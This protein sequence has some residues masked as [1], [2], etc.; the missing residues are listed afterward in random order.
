M[1]LQHATLQR[2]TREPQRAPC[3]VSRAACA[4]HRAPRGIALPT[5]A[6]CAVPRA[7]RPSPRANMRRAPCVARACVLRAARHRALWAP[8]THRL[9]SVLLGTPGTLDAAVYSQYRQ[10]YMV[11][12]VPR[13]PGTLDASPCALRRKQTNSTFPP[14]SIA[15]PSLCGR[16]DAQWHSGY[17]RDPLYR[18][19]LTVSQYSVVLTVRMQRPTL[20]R[21]GIPVARSRRGRR[22]R[23]Q[24]RGPL[25]TLEYPLGAP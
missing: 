17:S 12:T 10:Y 9:V 16:P 15:V 21:C 6:A 13:T 5:R 14:I 24:A 2:I 22:R 3:D 7:S 19:V 18:R 23:P 1:M 4:S 11:L 25:S 20:A 8:P